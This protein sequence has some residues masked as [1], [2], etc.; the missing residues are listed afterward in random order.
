MIEF[1]LICDIDAPNGMAKVYI[2]D[3][4]VTTEF[5]PFM[6]RFSHGNSESIPMVINEL[7][8][9][10]RTRSDRWFILGSCPNNIDRPYS[11]ASA[12][13]LGVKFT[14]GCRAEYDI[15]TSTLTVVTGGK[16]N[17]SAAQVYV[18]SPDISLNGAVTVLGMLT[19]SA[20]MTLSGA[21]GLSVTGG[22][23]KADNISLKSHKH[24]GVQP[25]AGLTTTSLP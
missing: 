25:G 9:V 15:A 23:I 3:T 13:K 22:D 12:D 19:A 14:D 20:G 8:L 18:T 2:P 21:A 10:G 7:V 17:I 1:G 5:I 16:V 11:G 6:R 24:G 4:G